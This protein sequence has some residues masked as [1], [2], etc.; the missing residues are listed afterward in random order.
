VDLERGEVGRH[1]GLAFYTIGQRRG[2]GV[3][4][5]EPRYVVRLDPETSTVVIG[6]DSALYAGRFTVRDVNW[7]AFDGPPDS[8]RADVK[9][10]YLT[11]PAPAEVAPSGAGAEVVFEE[12]QR[13]ITPGQAAVFYEGEALLGGGWIERS[14]SG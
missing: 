9:I 7:I 2:L 4:L 8:F 12:P 5:G 10:R 14:A 13:A 6:P 1:E 3:A 11:P